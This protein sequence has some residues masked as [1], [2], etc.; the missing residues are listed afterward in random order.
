MSQVGRFLRRGEGRYFHWC[1]AC[2][3]TH[4][5]PDRG[6]TFNGDFEKPTFTPSFKHNGV[7]RILVDGEWNGEWVRDAAGKAVPFVCHYILT[8][9]Q[10]FFCGDC[11]HAMK[12]K[13]V[14][15]PEWPP[16]LADHS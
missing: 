8:K 7:Q 1:P 15:L 16:D 10:L 12:N 3:D 9:G 6:W 11:T 14:P 4:Q 5:L 2:A 13:V